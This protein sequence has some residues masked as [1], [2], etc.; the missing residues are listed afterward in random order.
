MKNH[1]AIYH[2]LYFRASRLERFAESLLNNSRKSSHK[3]DALNDIEKFYCRLNFVLLTYENLSLFIT[4]I[5]ENF[6]EDILDNREKSQM[7]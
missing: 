7:E 4:R 2:K 3:H 1:K 5:V 6:Q